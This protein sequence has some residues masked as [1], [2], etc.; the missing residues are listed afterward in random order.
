[1]D[2]TVFFDHV[3]VRDA[4][5]RHYSRQS[6]DSA[7]WSRYRAAF[8]RVRVVSRVLEAQAAPAG[9]APADADGVSFEP[10]PYYVGPWQYALVRRRIA[11][12]IREL[13]DAPAAV[14]LR[15]PSTIGTLAWR[16]ITK[17]HP[18][19]PFGVEVVADPAE[20]LATG[21]VK[22]LLRPIAR[23]SQIR[24]MKAQCRQACAAAYVSRRLTRDY[25]PSS[26]DVASFYSSIDLADDDILVA[27]RAQFSAPPRLIHIGTMETHYK[28]QDVLLAALARRELEQA[29]LTFI[30]DGQNRAALE[31]LARR[32][33]VADR[34]RFAGRLPAGAAIRCVLDESDLF[35]LPS[36]T[37]GLPRAM[38]EAM[39][40]GLPCV[41]TAVGGIPELLEPDSL[42]PADDSAALA[43]RIAEFV[44]AP[45]RMLD[46]SRR[47]IAKAGEYRRSVLAARRAQFYERVRAAAAS[48]RNA[49]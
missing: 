21:A 16:M 49:D 14:I 9:V 8:E 48:W 20:T 7:F 37:E 22:S 34:V 17:Q 24:A 33:G 29:R 11:R 12:R 27:P 32:L 40:R 47:N 13:L 26:D 23:A 5:G 44:Q 41:G 35:V 2:L 4:G 38:I 3:F 45:S 31:T 15:I 6:F 10:L 18:G 25:P 42:V 39:A 28:A 1:M 46:A 30:G 43:A 36:R 19:R